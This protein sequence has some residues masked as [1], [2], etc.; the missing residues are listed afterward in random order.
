MT[1]KYHRLNMIS[2]LDPGICFAPSFWNRVVN[3]SLNFW[4]KFGYL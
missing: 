4:L 3:D 2:L 1:Q